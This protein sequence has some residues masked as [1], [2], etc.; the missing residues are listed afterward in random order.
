MYWCSAFSEERKEE[1]PSLGWLIHF[2]QKN[3]YDDMSRDENI[4]RFLVYFRIS[5]STP[6]RS[7]EFFTGLFLEERK[8]NQPWSGYRFILSR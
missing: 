7:H 5:L 2:E 4:T 6:D 3:Q 1:Q 8:E